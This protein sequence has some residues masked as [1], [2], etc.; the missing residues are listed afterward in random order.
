MG[1]PSC[2]RYC[3]TSSSGRQPNFAALNRGRHLCSAG[4]PS[5]W[6]LAHILVLVLFW[7][8]FG[9]VLRRFVS[10]LRAALCVAKCVISRKR[11]S[12]RCR[13]GR[14]HVGGRVGNRPPWKKSGWAMPTLEI[15]TVVW[16]PSGNSLSKKYSG[17]QLICTG[18][19]CSLLIMLQIKYLPRSMRTCE[20]H[21]YSIFLTYSNFG[22]II[23]TCKTTFYI[24]LNYL[25]LTR[26]N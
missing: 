1:F 12:G 11:P 25:N 21:A 24:R 9:F 7:V 15:P 2:Q 26:V 8:C 13:H 19:Q 17:E 4:R 23:E 18:L 20:W 5:R 16:K 6:A 22:V 3:M 14:R 10:V